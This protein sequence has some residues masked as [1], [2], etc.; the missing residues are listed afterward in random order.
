M[1]KVTITSDSGSILPEKSREHG[2]TM[3]PCPVIMDGK[4]YLDTEIDMDKLYARLESKE[5]LPTTS[6]ANM[7][8][9]AQF[10]TEIGQKAEAILHI[11]MSSVFS[12]HYNIA[13]QG[14]KLVGEKLPG[15]RVEVVHSQ[16][17]GTGVALLAMEAARAAAQGKDIDEVQKLVNDLIPQVSV[18]LARDTLFYQAEGGRIFEAQTW[19]EAESATSFR[20]ITEAD[21]STEGALK[22]VVRAKTVAQIMDK[23]VEL[24][25]ERA[26]GNRLV[27]IIGHARVPD[28]A[29]KLKR[30]LLSEVQFDELVVSEVSACVVVHGGI[31]IIDYSFCPRA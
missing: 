23:M 9:F 15:K 1:L 27:G 28:R 21:A 11:C 14:K 4:A 7:G 10:F 26:G 20:S 8:E 17:M 2:F 30:M 6:T 18:L 24:T 3:I 5:D 16:C 29:E 19:A 13:L 31:G 25:K 22:P 12:G